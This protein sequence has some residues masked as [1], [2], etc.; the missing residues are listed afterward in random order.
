M[1]DF[2]RRIDEYTEEL[3]VDLGVTSL[4]EEK[5]A[6]IF[7]RVQEHLRKVILEVSAQ[8]LSHK[9]LAKIKQGLEQENYHE[10]GKILKRRGQ[11]KSELEDKI[12]SEFN[13]LKLK[14]IEEQKDV[15]NTRGNS[16]AGEVRGT[17]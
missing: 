17:L 5:K 7:A 11:F 8:V 3:F 6:E 16:P 15:G 12:D 4:P 1:Y 14:I 13:Q 2:D 10:V 9:E